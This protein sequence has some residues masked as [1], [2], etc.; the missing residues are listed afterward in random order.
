[1]LPQ[2]GKSLPPFSH[3]R[4]TRISLMPQI[5]EPLILLACTGAVSGAFE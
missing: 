1:L 2:R 4:K 5:E 3:F